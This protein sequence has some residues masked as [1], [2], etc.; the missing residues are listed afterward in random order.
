[1]FLRFPSLLQVVNTA[2]AFASVYPVMRAEFNTFCFVGWG[3][4]EW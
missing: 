4:F 1:M 3:F 2:I